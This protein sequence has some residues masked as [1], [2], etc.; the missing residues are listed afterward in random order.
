MSDHHLR[1]S[2]ALALTLAACGGGEAG[3]EEAA[4]PPSN[5]P[6]AG[7]PLELEPLADAELMGLDRGQVVLN[8][9]WS[10]NVLA[11][12]PAPSSARATLQS[13]DVARGPSF[14]RIA[15]RFGTDAP[16]PGYRVVWNDLNTAG[17]GGQPAQELPAERTLLVA[18]EPAT[19]Q[20]GPA[21]SATSVAAG[22]TM[23]ERAARACDRADRL[24]WA[25][26]AADSG[27]VR[28]IELRDPPRL[29]VDVQHPTT[30][31]AAP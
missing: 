13:V 21:A 10:N 27:L 6:Q 11:R 19:A 7:P 25:L 9:P 24:V 4:P 15:F 26:S 23:I 8:L 20:E 18:L 28:T 12:S 1:W 14:D 22:L 16:F 2:V 3:E 29:I 30:G 5:V 17:C 31:A